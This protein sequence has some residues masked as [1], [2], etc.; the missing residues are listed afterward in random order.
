MIIGTEVGDFLVQPWRQKVKDQKPI[1]YRELFAY[2][3]HPDKAEELFTDIRVEGY[4]KALTGRYVGRV[5]IFCPNNE[6]APLR[7]RMM[8]FGAPADVIEH[9]LSLYTTYH[10]GTQ[11]RIEMAKRDLREDEVCG[12]SSVYHNRTDFFGKALHD[13][14]IIHIAA[15][16]FIFAAARKEERPMILDRLC[17]EYGDGPLTRLILDDVMGIGERIA[18]EYELPPQPQV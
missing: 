13:L 11:M 16:A 7:D 15:E 2:G 8:A 4:A 5:I 3:V 18:G 12:C 10:N 14:S 1:R 6:F 9:R 17:A